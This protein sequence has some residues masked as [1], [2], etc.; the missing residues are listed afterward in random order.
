M[1]TVPETFIDILMGDADELTYAEF[2]SR[3]FAELDKLHMS[4][5]DEF[6]IVGAWIALF[7]HVIEDRR[8]LTSE[9][10]TLICQ[11]WERIVAAHE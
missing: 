5:A 2:D 6:I 4:E 11:T 7:D 8:A 10:N 3:F 9:E 1:T